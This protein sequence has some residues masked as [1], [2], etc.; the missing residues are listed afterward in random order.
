MLERDSG[1][2]HHTG[3]VRCRGVYITDVTNA[4]GMAQSF[5]ESPKDLQKI[6]FGMPFWVEFL[7]LWV[8]TCVWVCFL[9]SPLYNLPLKS[10]EFLQGTWSF[11]PKDS[12]MRRFPTSL[13][14][15]QKRKK[16]GAFFLCNH[17]DVSE[18]SGTPK[19]SI[20]IEFFIIHHPFWGTPIFGNTHVVSGGSYS[21]LTWDIPSIIIGPSCR[22]VWMVI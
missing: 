16:I 17:V 12:C 19:S 21:T 2:A 9:F 11:M 13:P 22:G 7:R 6:C 18:N 14:S 5:L 20:L 4:W 10:L 3:R 15:L 1:R 8:S